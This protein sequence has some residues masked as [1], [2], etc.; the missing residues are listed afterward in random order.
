[1]GVGQ[2]VEL[3]WLGVPPPS[4]AP[5]R[6]Q[7]IGPLQAPAQVRWA[8]DTREDGDTHT[9]THRATALAGAQVCILPIYPPPWVN[10][11]QARGCASCSRWK[12]AA[13]VR[14]LPIPSPNS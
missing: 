3:G 1:M 14:K 10:N 12:A 13:V 11:D 4:L 6:G 2:Q 8:K 9:H 7:G 5:N